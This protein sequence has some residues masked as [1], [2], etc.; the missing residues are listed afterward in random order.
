MCAAGA[1]I[2]TAAKAALVTAADTDVAAAAC[3]AATFRTPATGRVA[4]AGCA[5]RVAG[6]APGVAAIAPRSPAQPGRLA[7]IHA[8]GEPATYGA[9]TSAPATRTAAQPR[10]AATTV[11]SARTTVRAAA[12]VLAAIAS[13]HTPAHPGRQR[14]DCHADRRAYRCAHY[15]ADSA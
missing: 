6:C 13:P 3:G 7:S 10:G 12:A 5:P 15:G 4:V 8:F 11:V 9:A 14:P 1:T 2:A